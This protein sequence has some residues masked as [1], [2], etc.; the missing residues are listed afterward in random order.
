MRKGEQT[1]AAIL[2]AAL[3]LAARRGLEGLT[4]GV[5]AA[6][7]RMSKSGV[8]AH[9]G[10]REDLQI[11][12]LKHYERRFVESVL[13]PASRPPAD[14]RGCG[15]CSATGSPTRRWRPSR[16]CIWISGAVE[17]DDRPG[18][19]RDELVAM[20][21]SWQREL[22]RAIGQAVE[23]GELRPDTDVSAAVFD[24]YGVI[25]VLH[26]DARLLRR[27]GAASRALEAF[28]RIIAYFGPR[29]GRRS[30]RRR[31][32]EPS[33]IAGPFCQSNRS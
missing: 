6:R 1:R 5:L 14:S 2:D 3:D 20:V 4:I 23:L 19:V 24:I 31:R 17:Y 28:E 27:P 32:G 11:A 9:F 22:S 7:M 29:S 13:L 15:P 21:M 25:L 10:S 16:A 12:V 30:R 33:M 18:A 8:F 26:H